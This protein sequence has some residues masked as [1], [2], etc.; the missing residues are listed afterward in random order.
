MTG[1]AATTDPL[2]RA[3][4]EAVAGRRAPLHDFLAR[5]SHLPGPRMNDALADAFAAACRTR[6]A[7][8]DEVAVALARLTPNEAPGATALEFLPVCGLLAIGARAA[9]DAG[10]RSRLVAELHAH[11]DDA[12]FRAREAVVAAL[13]KVGGAAGDDLTRDTAA[14]MD[15]Y[16]HAAAVLRALASEAWL[17]SL[18]DAGEVVARYD[19]ALALL[20]AAPRAAARWPG[21]KELLVAI[22][23]SLPV[24]AA[25]FGVPVFDMLVRWGA[26]DDPVLREMLERAV[27]ARKLSGRRGPEVERVRRA[28]EASRP[29]PRNPDHDVGPTRDRSGSRKRGRRP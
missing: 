16:F 9:S 28:L 6:G 4:D 2:A 1:P 29:A 24:A 22:E 21:H 5:G 7:R 14:W 15:G 3:L 10:A 23:Q 19:D 11:A 18:R 25:H 26:V 20:R 27:S 12:R 17:G 13:G 8:T